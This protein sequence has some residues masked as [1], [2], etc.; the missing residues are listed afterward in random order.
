[1]FHLNLISF[2]STEAVISSITVCACIDVCI[3]SVRAGVFFLTFVS[4]FVCDVRI[5]MCFSIHVCVCVSV[6]AR[7]CV[8]VCVCVFVSVCAS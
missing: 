8:F 7:A 6:C 3:L 4:S 5:C 2:G 1:M